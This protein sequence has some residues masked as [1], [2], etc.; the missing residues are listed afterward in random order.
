MHFECLVVFVG[1]SGS[2]FVYLGSFFVVCFGCIIY[3][4]GEV[5]YLCDVKVWVDCME[6]EFFTLEVECEY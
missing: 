6:F 5:I 4:F 1:C 3:C 2:D